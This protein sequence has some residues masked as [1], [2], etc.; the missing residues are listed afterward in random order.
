MWVLFL[1]FAFLG[2]MVA[3]IANLYPQRMPDGQN[4]YLSQHGWPPA[5]ALAA[6]GLVCIAWGWTLHRKSAQWSIDPT[7]GRRM[8]LRPRHSLYGIR[9]EI[10]GLLFMGLGS[11]FV[12]YR[13]L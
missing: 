7:T 9:M 12:I 3:L 13:G 2:G 6:A 1:P 5:L 11:L 4:V 10:W 8:L